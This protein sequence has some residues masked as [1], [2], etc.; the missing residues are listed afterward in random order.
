MTTKTMTPALVKDF[1]NDKVK[2]KMVGRF[3]LAKPKEM[4]K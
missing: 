2:Y 1:S 4:E 3:I